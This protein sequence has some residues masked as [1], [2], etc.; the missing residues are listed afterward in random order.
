MKPLINEGNPNREALSRNR[1][2]ARKRSSDVNINTYPS[3]FAF[4]AMK[5]VLVSTGNDPNILKQNRKSLQFLKLLRQPR[6][7]N[8]LINSLNGSRIGLKEN[9]PGLENKVHPIHKK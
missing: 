1:E 7:T 6:G 3:K 9:N 8:P 2:T 5:S 4:K